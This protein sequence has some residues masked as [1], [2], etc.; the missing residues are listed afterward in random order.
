MTEAKPQTANKFWTKINIL[1]SDL[2]A[3]SSH[4]LDVE[5]PLTPLELSEVLVRL[6]MQALEID[7]DEEGENTAIEY[8]PKNSYDKGQR[9]FFPELNNKEGSVLEV[10]DGSAPDGTIFKVIKVDLDNG[11]IREFASQ[12]EEHRLNEIPEDNQEEKND[13][14][15]EIMKND[16]AMII[17]SLETALQGNDDF[18]YIAGC[19][20][21]SALTAD[22]SEG[23]LNLAEALLDMAGGGPLSTQEILDQIGGPEG[24][25]KKLASFSLDLALQEDERFDEVGTTG[26]VSWFLKKLEPEDVQRTPL[27]L[28]YEEAEYNRQSL[29]EEMLSLE[30][31]IHDELSSLEDQEDEDLEEVEITLI[32]PH[33]RSG[34]LPLT[35]SMVKLFPTAYDSPRV[36]F[37]FVDGESRERYPGWVVRSERYVDGL[38]KWYTQRE[39]MPGSYVRARRGERQGEIIVNADSHRSSKEWVRTA[40]IGSDGG[41]VYAMLKQKVKSAFDERMMI[42]LPEDISSLDEGWKSKTRQLDSVVLHAIKELTK[43]SPQ[44]HAHA[45]EI[46]AAVNVLMRCPPGPIFSLLSS[47]Q[48]IEHIGHLHFRLTD[49]N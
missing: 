2:A 15:I 6:R 10:R 8:I 37:E 46:Y 17:A 16:G 11:L 12:L 38:R 33:W 20:F 34:S 42:Y 26:I 14:V 29:S 25:N 22:F 9:L 1:P 35:N 30:K 4:L 5:I 27:F 18:V 49:E 36:R 44:N 19:W 45:N 21:P 28:R 48:E 3:I 13:P 32:F 31:R 40:L 39:M 7:K 47:L 23:Q 24:S 43:L 41:V